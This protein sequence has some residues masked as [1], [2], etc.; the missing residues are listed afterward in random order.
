MSQPGQRSEDAA[1][2]YRHTQHKSSPSARSAFSYLSRSTGCPSFCPA[3]V[4]V[5]DGFQGGEKRIILIVTSLSECTSSFF[6]A[7]LGLLSMKARREGG[8]RGGRRVATWRHLSTRGA[9]ILLHGLEHLR[10]HDHGLARDLALAHHLACRQ[11]T[12]AHNGAVTP[13]VRRASSRPRRVLL[14]IT[15][16]AWSTCYST[17]FGEKVKNGNCAP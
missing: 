6:S 4:W 12:T 1:H 8:R 7:S 15:R 14:R 9:R 5:R 2:E 13:L 3:G 16:N 11:H 17:W 10:G